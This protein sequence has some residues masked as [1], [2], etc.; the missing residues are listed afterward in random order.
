M[1]YHV[2]LF[3]GIFQ[4]SKNFYQLRD[5]EHVKFLTGKLLL[6]ILL[7]TV[8]S[9]LQGNFGIGTESFTNKLTNDTVEEF[10]RLKFFFTLGHVIQ[11]MLTPLLYLFLSSTI[12]WLVFEVDFVKLLIIHAYVLWIYEI[13]D[14]IL[15]PLQLLLGIQDIFSP[16]SLGVWG[17]FFTNSPL[18]W[19]ILGSISLF[20]FWA[21]IIQIIAFQLLTEKSRTFIIL[22]VFTANLL[23]VLFTAL[24]E[25]VPIEKLL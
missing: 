9:F 10:E 2:E 14:V 21:L 7:S 12:F 1:I 20:T 19:S 22:A 16:F 15:L 8:V 17:P 11:G 23:F 18:L 6:I 4:P 13:E 3:K 5:A 25:N 24:V